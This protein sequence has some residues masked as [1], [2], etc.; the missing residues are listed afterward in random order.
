MASKAKQSKQDSVGAGKNKEVRTGNKEELRT[1][2]GDTSMEMLVRERNSYLQK[3]YKILTEHMNTYMGRVERFLLENKFLEEEAKRNRK[4]SNIY[5]SYL[6]K[7]S[8]RCQNLIITL[9]EQNETHLSQVQKQ[10]EQLISQYTEKEK[11]VRSCLMEVERKYSLMNTEVEDL[12]PFKDLQ[13]EQTKKMKD[14][15]LEKQEAG[16]NSSLLCHSHFKL[17]ASGFPLSHQQRHQSPFWLL[18]LNIYQIILK[19]K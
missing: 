19:Y 8:Q 10:K 18:S 17:N 1:K 6:A 12:Q 15:S 14:V 4:E 7:H 3:E 13:L 9:N 2:N 11:E 5:L 16:S